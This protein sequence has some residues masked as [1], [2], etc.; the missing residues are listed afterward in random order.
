MT[1]EESGAFAALSMILTAVVKVLPPETAHQV[2]RELRA[3]QLD[4][5]HQDGP[6][7]TD[8]AFRLGRDHLVNA[9]REL[10]NNVAEGNVYL[11][12]GGKKST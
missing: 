11:V 6:D 12:G 5:K 3:A 10:L 9:Y 2:A 7:R 8:P 4:A 1:Q